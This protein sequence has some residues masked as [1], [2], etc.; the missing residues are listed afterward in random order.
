M[1]DAPEPADS[2]AAP[3]PEQGDWRWWQVAVSVGAALAIALIPVTPMGLALM[4]EWAP[5]GE[6]GDIVPQEALLKE[7]LPIPDY[8]GADDEEATTEA[9]PPEEPEE[10]EPDE[11]EVE[12]A[13]PAAAPESAP[14]LLTTEG[15]ASLDLLLPEATEEQLLAFSDGEPE[16][17]G[18]AAEGDGEADG[19]GK[20]ERSKQRER[21]KPRGKSKSA[22]EPPKPCTDFHPGITKSETDEN[23]YIIERAL[24]EYYAT[25]IFELQQLGSVW[26][27]KD[28][29][30][31]PDGFQIGIR[32]CGILWQ[33]G[34][35]SRD[36]IHSVNGRTITTI[37]QALQAYFALRNEEVFTVEIA[38]KKQP[39]TLTF[40][41]VDDRTRKE[42]RDAQKA[43]KEERKAARK[44]EKDEGTADA[45]PSASADAKP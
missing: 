20:S 32:R 29:T 6:Y 23:A 34:F 42:I 17:E 30:G 7:Y 11:P 10:D 5:V 45:P 8:D 24:V 12:E 26:T 43:A 37:F 35:R 38:R 2:D 31:T 25:H 4:Q 22:K 1:T 40:T 39:M 19:D 28:I 33:S 14:V 36:I 13:A 15:E 21:R 18:D 16:G 9:L 44:A 27:H 3:I 41:L